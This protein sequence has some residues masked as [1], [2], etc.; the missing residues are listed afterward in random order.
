[1]MIRGIWFICFTS[2]ILGCFEKEKEEST[3]FIYRPDVKVSDISYNNIDYRITSVRA[4]D[5]R[6]C[7][8][9]IDGIRKIKSLG[10]SLYQSGR[11]LLFATNGGI[12]GKNHY[13]GGLFIQNKEVIQNIN[14]RNAS[15]NFHLLPNGCFYLT[16]KGEA[17]VMESNAFVAKADISQ[18]TMGVQSGPMLIIDGEYHPAFNEGSKNLHIRNG[19]GVDDDGNIHFVISGQRT[20]FY[21]MATIFKENLKCKN[22]LYLD[23]AIS[24]MYNHGISKEHEVYRNFATIFFVDEKLE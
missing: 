5:L 24:E 23:G 13:P 8:Y 6:M 10:D 11:Q 1:M 3:T 19:V 2:L 21:D 20:N 7:S 14:L 15:G 17:H 12:F 18:I 9:H 16:Q 22:A 4:K